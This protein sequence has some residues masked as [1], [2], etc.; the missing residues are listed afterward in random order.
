MKKKK[1]KKWGPTPKEFHPVN[2]EKYCGSFP[3]IMR[4]SWET[5]FAM[6]CDK[7]PSVIK[8]GSESTI[9]KYKDQSRNN[10]VHR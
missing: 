7:S 5:K 8:W 2:K 10:T 6:F 4:S 9:V 1:N 3:I